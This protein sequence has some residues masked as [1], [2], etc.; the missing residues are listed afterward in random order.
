MKKA[1]VSCIC[2]MLFV[3]CAKKDER[4]ENPLLSS[5]SLYNKKMESLKKKLEGEQKSLESSAKEIE[6]IRS[7]LH[8]EELSLIKKRV[9]EF[10]DYLKVLKEDQ[11]KYSAF[12]RNE[13]ANLFIKEREALK[14]IIQSTGDK[15]EAQETLE[16]ILR[17]I[18]TIN[19][20]ATSQSNVEQLHF[21]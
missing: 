3:G 2:V 6:K 8:S 10:E 9:D 15:K 11:A 1:L 7:D 4:I 20:N 16:R 5:E 19:N 17:L 18:T 21:R 12:L 14:G 13:L